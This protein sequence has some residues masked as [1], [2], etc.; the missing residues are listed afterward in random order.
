MQQDPRIDAYIAKAEPFARP[1]LEHLRAIVHRGCLDID[2][3]MKWSFPHFDYKGIVCS[4]AAFK[5][6]CAFGFW[7]GSLLFKNDEAKEGE[8]MG[9]FGRIRA[10]SDLPSDKVLISYVRKAVEL[11]VA[12]IKVLD[13]PKPNSGRIERPEVPGDL[14]VALK[15]NAKARTTYENFSPSKQKEYVEWLIGA[16]RDATRQ[17]RLATAIEW[18]ADGK[19]HHWRYERK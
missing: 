13:P 8:S 6:H 1:I 9:Q 17:Q 3:T 15:K 16:K 12:G 14:A 5:A 4:M 10:L 2:E 7:K 18:M 11:N 19:S